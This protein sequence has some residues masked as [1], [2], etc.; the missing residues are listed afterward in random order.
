MTTRVDFYQLSRDPV[1]KVAVMLAR[2][3]IQAGEKLLIVSEDPGQRAVIGR[4]LWR[5]GP[6]EFLANGEAATD[7]AEKQPILLSEIVEAP[8]GAGMVIL[9]D[10]KWRS[11]AQQFKRALL[12]FGTAETEAARALWRELDGAEGVEREIH[13]QDES[14]RWR[15]GA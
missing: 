2:K 8:N 11:E 10:G 7:H 3:V 15:A 12:L 13:K 14:G 5:G 6:E 1:E 9:A 4:E